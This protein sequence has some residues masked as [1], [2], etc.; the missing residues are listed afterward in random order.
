MHSHFLKK[1]LKQTLHNL[2]LL[3]DLNLFTNQCYL[4]ACNVKREQRVKTQGLQGQKKENQC[5]YQNAQ[6]VT[7]KNKDLLKSKKLVGYY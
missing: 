5:I 4:L 7:V 1:F 2:K 6:C 3:K